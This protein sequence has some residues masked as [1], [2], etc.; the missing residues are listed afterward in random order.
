MANEIRRVEPSQFPFMASVTQ[1]YKECKIKHLN[2]KGGPVL[3]EDSTIEKMTSTSHLFFRN[4]NVGDVEAAGHIVFIGDGRVKS[5]KAG[6]DLHIYRDQ[7]D[8][9]ATAAGHVLQIVSFV[10]DSVTYASVQTPHLEI[11]AGVKTVTL[12]E[13]C[14]VRGNVIFSEDRV[15]PSDKK[16]ILKLGAQLDGDV[17]GGNLVSEANGS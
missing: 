1:T 16:V 14:H 2:S 8:F 15:P 6:G 7:I 17:I 9:D 4:C 5:L 3:I 12:G 10:P 13:K 11:G